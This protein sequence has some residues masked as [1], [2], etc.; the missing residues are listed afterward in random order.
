MPCSKAPSS[1]Y[2]TLATPEELYSHT[3]IEP[4]T[5]KTFLVPAKIRGFQ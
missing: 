1:D 5:T 3:V 4:N 2:I